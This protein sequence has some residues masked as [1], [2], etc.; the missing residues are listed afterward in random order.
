MDIHIGGHWDGEKLQLSFHIVS[1][2]NYK[3]DHIHNLRKYIKLNKF[4]SGES[5]CV[6]QLGKD[7][8]Q[9]QK[10]GPLKSGKFE[11][12]QIKQFYSIKDTF[13]KVKRKPETEKIFIRH[14]MAKNLY[15]EF[16]KT[17]YN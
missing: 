3:E 17:S 2:V 7:L 5:H 15:L 12:I 8:I 11:F 10:Y 6:L 16:I 9:H 1:Q 4:S 14:I 13:K